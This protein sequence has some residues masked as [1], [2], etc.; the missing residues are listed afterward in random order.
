MIPNGLFC[1][2]AFV[3]PDTLHRRKYN[4]GSDDGRRINLFHMAFYP[5]TCIPLHDSVNYNN[6]LSTA[7]LLQQNGTENGGGTAAHC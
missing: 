5:D 1:P 4:S 3:F 7:F 2:G 6:R